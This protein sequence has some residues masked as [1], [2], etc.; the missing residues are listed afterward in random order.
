[1]RDFCESGKIGE[2]SAIG[3]KLPTPQPPEYY[4]FSHNHNAKTLRRPAQTRV[5]SLARKWGKSA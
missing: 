5:L 1:L 2:K 3:A 4:D